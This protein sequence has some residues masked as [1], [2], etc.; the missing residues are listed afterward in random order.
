[1]RFP[2]AR[3]NAVQPGEVRFG[4][5][6]SRV[7]RWV[8]RQPMNAN[9]GQASAGRY[10]PNSIRLCKA[11]PRVPSQTANQSAASVLRI[12]ATSAHWPLICLVG[13]PVGAGR[14][15]FRG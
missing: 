9:A 4:A 12:A 1:M 11:H 14:N 7:K 13:F 2:E 15:V 10:K 8:T 6:E 3:Q 5:A